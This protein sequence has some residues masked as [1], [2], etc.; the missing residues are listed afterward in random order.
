MKFIYPNSRGACAPLCWLVAMLL[1]APALAWAKTDS[2][3]QAL[4]LS[5][6]F[7]ASVYQAVEAASA[8]GKVEPVKNLAQFAQRVNGL[9]VEQPAQALMALHRN[10]KFLIQNGNKP[11][12]QT[13]IHTALQLQDAQFVRE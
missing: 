7:E 6:Q 3:R 11:D 2:A 9:K 1:L 13:L 10:K 5:G 8:Q 12:T 4:E